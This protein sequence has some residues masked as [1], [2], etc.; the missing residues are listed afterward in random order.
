MS[1]K[2][3]T[4]IIT[5]ASSGIGREAAL[6]LGKSGVRVALLARRE[7]NLNSAADAIRDAGGDA[8]VLKTDVTSEDDVKRAVRRT[9]EEYDGIDYL[10]NVAGLGI[11]KP[12]EELSPAEW[13][14]Q[15]GV[16]LTG[17]FLMTHF[18]L[19][20][21][22]RKRQG[23]VVFVTSLWGPVKTAADCSAY[24]A[25]KA[26]VSALADAL[27]EEVREK[28][29]DVGVTEIRPGTVAT[30]FFDKA[31]YKGSVDAQRVLSASDVAGAVCDVLQAR[32]SVA[33]NTI[34]IEGIN[35][36]Y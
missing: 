20:H 13:N 34:E 22:Y 6:K 1:L 36:P 23:R 32:F 18:T 35:P 31:D 14:T 19:P 5:G 8:L 30:E 2:N 24:N 9:A 4:A 33:H 29:L 7:S 25:A 15:I 27:R 10:I 17:A 12:V 11:F 16:M 21:I 26:G 3:R 28:E